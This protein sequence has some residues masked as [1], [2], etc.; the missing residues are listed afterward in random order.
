MVDCAGLEEAGQLLEELRH[1]PSN[2]NAV[3]FAIASDQ[4]HAQLAATAG[5]NF[6]IERASLATSLDQTLRVAFGMIFRER[7]RYFRCPLDEFIS[8][9][10][11]GGLMWRGKL[12]NL[13]EGGAAVSIDLNLVPCELVWLKFCLPNST[14]QIDVEAEVCWTTGQTLKGFAFKAIAEPHRNELQ[15]WL[16]EELEKRLPADLLCRLG[17]LGN[18]T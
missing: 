8:V 9:R 7:R 10:R 12:V 18:R 17:V 3:A 6:V 2:Y 13:S 5:A 11:H 15:N 4:H 1:S 14:S 16:S